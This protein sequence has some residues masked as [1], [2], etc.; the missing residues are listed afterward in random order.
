VSTCFENIFLSHQIQVVSANGIVQPC[1]I[2]SA[3][4][5]SHS[6]QAK[7]T[8][9]FIPLFYSTAEHSQQGGPFF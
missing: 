2:P 6:M 1:R 3:H 5:L 8:L 7:S 4:S 9:F